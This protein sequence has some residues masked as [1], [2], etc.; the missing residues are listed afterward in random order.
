MRPSFGWSRWCCPDVCEAD[1]HPVRKKWWVYRWG[2]IPVWQMTKAIFS[3]INIQPEWDGELE[4]CAFQWW[5]EAAV[6]GA[7]VVYLYIYIYYNI[8]SP[9]KRE[10]VGATN[11][12]SPPHDTWGHTCYVAMSYGVGDTIG[13]SVIEVANHG[14]NGIQC[15][16]AADS[17]H[18]SMIQTLW[19]MLFWY[20]M[21]LTSI[22]M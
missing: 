7:V 4:R 15:S 13:I 21:V 2:I 9:K 17:H 19:T 16:Q 14:I 1:P 12:V 10:P 6:K 5:M 11:R 20:V 8:Y 3:W 22:T 18:T